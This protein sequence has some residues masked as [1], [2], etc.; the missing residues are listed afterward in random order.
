MMRH[1]YSIKKEAT[2]HLEKKSFRV[3]TCHILTLLSK[4]IRGVKYWFWNYHHENMKF[5]TC[6]GII[7][8]NSA[9]NLSIPFKPKILNL[10]NFRTWKLSQIWFQLISESQNWNFSN[11]MDQKS[12]FLLIFE[13]ERFLNFRGW[14]FEFWSNFRSKR[15]NF[16]EN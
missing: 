14:K 1:V 6:R 15:L 5:L 8:W 10:I 4:R 7:S 9:Q 12:Y 3:T 2:A 11:L 16:C 13:P